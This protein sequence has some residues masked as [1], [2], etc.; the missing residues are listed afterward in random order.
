MNAD[1]FIKTSRLSLRTSLS[2]IQNPNG[3][4]ASF[5]MQKLSPEGI[6]FA[7]GPGCVGLLNTYS[8]RN[9]GDAAIMTALA[10]LVSGKQVIAALRD[11][12]PVPMAGVAN[13]DALE[14]ADR[15]ISVGGDIFNNA[16]PWLATRSFVRNVGAL[17]AAGQRGIMFGQTIPASCRGPALIGLSLAMRRLAGVVVRDQESFDLLRRYGVRARISF[18]TAFVIEATDAGRARALAMLDE[19]AIDPSRA[20]LIS[21]RS[22]DA[23]YPSDQAK[24]EQKLAELARKLHERGHQPA[25]LIQ[26]DVDR[27]DSDLQTAGRLRAMVP[28]LKILDCINRADDPAPVATLVGLLS[29]ANIAV[30]LRYH[31]TVLRLAVGRRAFNLYYSRKGRDL[32]QRLNLPGVHIDDFDAD[33]DIRAIEESADQMFN[34]S[35]VAENV[36]SSFRETYGAIQ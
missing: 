7:G 28:E 6:G 36:R 33:R 17:A 1:Q 11:S 30:G 27:A 19:A 5:Q 8:S 4:L 23:L 34:V 20:A 14:M 12:R 10:S 24:T 35:P 29:I 15:F 9:L 26:S 3:Q 18:D 22:F 25:V 21:V 2:Q 16:R 31:T 32:S 13:A